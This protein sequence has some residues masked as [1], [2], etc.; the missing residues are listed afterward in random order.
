MEEKKSFQMPHT[1]IIIFGVILLAALLTVFVPLGKYNTKEITYIQNGVE[2]ARVVLDPSS[3]EYVLDENG[4][5]VTKVAPL[6]G[7]ED[8]G[9]QGILNYVFE[10]MT[11]G[12]KWGTAV[13]IIAF[14]LVIGGAFG[15]VLRT[16]AIESGIAR[17]IVLTKGNDIILIPILMVMFSLGGAIFGMSEE[18][19]PFVMMLVPMFIAMGY[20]SIVA[21]MTCY[22]ATQV[23]FATSW[24]NPFSLAVAQGI[25]GIPVMSGA[26][27]RIPMWMIF[28]TVAIIFTVRYAMKI[29]KNPTLS[30]A[31][32]SDE[33]YRQEFAKKGNELPPFTLGHKLVILTVAACI[34]WTIWGVVS[35]G[36][37]IPEIASQFFVMG[38]VSGIIGV[39]F[40]LNGMKLNDIPVSFDRGAADLLGAAMCV[41]MAQGII[42]VLGGTDPTQGTVLNTILHAISEAM[43]GLPSVLSAWLMY[44]FQ[45]VFNFFVVSGSG[46][47]ALTMPVMAPLADLVGVERQ[48]AVVAFQLGDGFTNFIVPTSGVL[49]GALA[50][51]KL[52]WGVWAK[53]Q[54]KF[55]AVLFTMATAT[56]V[57]GV[58]IGLS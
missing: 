22:V 3:F 11:V 36:Y 57:I 49:L 58:L 34:V 14:I 2:K 28:T 5:K 18:T 4:E 48:V 29:K 8:F 40:K 6:F 31:Y 43:Q 53:F 17:V 27:F 20:D 46:Q 38:L 15:I 39:V 32:K 52:D 25:A 33:F 1:Y 35:Q 24:Q 16:G 45:S 42:I 21:I 7:T 10:G 9:G 13:G 56:M 51:A 44:I 12:D 23:G 37:Y 30:V 50:A 54:I 26:W 55:Q 47:A 41:G 19:I